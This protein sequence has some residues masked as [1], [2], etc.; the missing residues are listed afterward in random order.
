MNRMSIPLGALTCLLWLLCDA[1]V[2]LIDVKIRK[3]KCVLNGTEIENGKSVNL[4]KPCESRTCDAKA[5]TVE[6]IGCGPI[7]AP[8]NCTLVNGTGIFPK[9]CRHAVCKTT[10]KKPINITALMS[11]LTKC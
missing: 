6:I 4:E 1:S 2:G 7:V 8:P 5:K 10:G 11:N 9:C 3:G